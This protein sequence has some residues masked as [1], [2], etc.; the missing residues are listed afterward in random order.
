MEA[1]SETRANLRFHTKLRKMHWLAACYNL[2]HGNAWMTTYHAF[3]FAVESIAVVYHKH[4]L[5]R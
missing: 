4:Q 3:C 2:G 5:R 1:R